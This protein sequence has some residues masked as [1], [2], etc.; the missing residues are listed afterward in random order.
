M[1]TFAAIMPLFRN[2]RLTLD[3]YLVIEKMPQDMGIG[4]AMYPAEV[5]MLEAIRELDGASI[6]ALA[7]ETGVTKGAVSQL[8]AKLADKRLVEKTPAP[9]NR[10]RLIIRCTQEGCT[11]CDNHSKFHREHDKEFIAYLQH[12]EEADFHALC[13]FGAQMNKWM[14]AYLK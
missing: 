3:K 11:V 4:Q 14:D 5:H 7:R 10:S 6:T 12:L 9:D 2:L 8:V 13:V 1:R